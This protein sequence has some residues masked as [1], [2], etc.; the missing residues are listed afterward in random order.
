MPF[1]PITEETIQALMQW[2]PPDDETAQRHAQLNAGFDPILGLCYQFGHTVFPADSIGGQF[3]NVS[4]AVV[5]AGKA[6]VEH[7]PQGP[8]LSAAV[9]SLRLCRNALNEFLVQIRNGGRVP[10]DSD[11]V[12]YAKQYAYEAK[13]QGNGG[14]ALEGRL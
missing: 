8:D 13:W 2:H 6:L 4:N 7:V 9:R 5:A 10:A 1:K 12:T 11:L 14:I 3:E